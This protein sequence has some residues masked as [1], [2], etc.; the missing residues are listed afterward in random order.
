M[1]DPSID[2]LEAEC[3]EN[4]DR[5]RSMD[6]SI[7]QQKKAPPASESDSSLLCSCFTCL[8]CSHIPAKKKTPTKFSHMTGKQ[9][10]LMIR[11]RKK[12]KGKGKGRSHGRLFS[13]S[14]AA[15]KWFPL[16]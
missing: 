7:D 16:R 14:P 5:A 15:E 6:R 4:L 3:R 9:L 12:G 2:P 10:L 8:Y 13:S 1:H 11:K